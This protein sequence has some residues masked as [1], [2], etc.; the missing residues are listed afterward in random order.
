MGQDRNALA[1]PPVSGR[2]VRSSVAASLD[3]TIAGRRSIRSYRPEAVT[4]TLLHEILDLAR[5]APSSMDG[6]PCH[7]IVIRDPATRS[8]L[9][10]I[11]DAHCPP[12]KRAFPA[13]FL[14]DTPVVIAVCVDRQRSHD[15]PV[16]NAVLAT[17]FL[18]LAAASRGLGSVYLSAHRDGDPAL[19]EEIRAL[20]TLPSHVDPVTLVPLGYARATAPPK[21]LRSLEEIV[22]DDLFRGTV[23]ARRRHAP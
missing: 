16:E 21:R 17:A 5:H 18:L 15:R 11:K 8:R 2:A 1:S 20:L 9:A 23:R 4:D 10:A 14:A 6:Q 19:R 3:E 12:E 7:F 13:D 22:H